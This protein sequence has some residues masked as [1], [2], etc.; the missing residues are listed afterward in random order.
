L[1]ELIEDI[2]LKAVAGKKDHALHTQH[3]QS[4]EGCESRRRFF[5]W[6]EDPD[7]QSSDGVR[8]STVRI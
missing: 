2:V 4:E 3:D 5:S 6:L 7:R 1:A 8:G